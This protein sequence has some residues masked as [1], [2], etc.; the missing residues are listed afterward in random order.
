MEKKKEIFFILVLV[1]V[2][3][4]IYQPTLKYDL[5]WDTQTFI[6]ES[7]LLKSNVSPLSAFK[8]GYIYG[9][10][11]MQEQS[12]YYRPLVNLSF[13]L[14]RELWGLKNTTLRLTNLFIFA[15]IVVFLFWVMSNRLGSR[16][17]QFLF[18]FL[19]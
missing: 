9:Q 14:E 19:R 17:R 15:L 4:I 13:M 5:I 12:F 3:V 10:L 2:M 6:D 1:T 8:Y 11:G 7:F 16:F 18:Y